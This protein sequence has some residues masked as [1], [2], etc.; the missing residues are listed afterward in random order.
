M[1]HFVYPF[2]GW[3]AY[4]L[5]L[6]MAIRNNAAMNNL[7][8]FFVQAFVFSFLGYWLEMMDPMRSLEGCSPWGRWGSYTT[9]RLHFHFSLSCIGG[10]GNPLQCSCLENP[11]NR[12]AWWAAVSGVAQSQTRLKR[13]SCM[14]ALIVIFWDTAKFFSIVTVFHSHHQHKR[15]PIFPHPYQHSFFIFFYYCHHTG[16]KWYLIVVLGFFGLFFFFL[17][18][19]SL[20]TDD[21][22]D[23]W[24]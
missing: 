23:W 7:L 4:G 9:E 24:C 2:V 21:V 11:R 15:I 19:I 1:L 5:F 14:L 10:N 3:W 6:P 13:L 16:C 17:V 8:A 12:G 18:F 20:K 22:Q